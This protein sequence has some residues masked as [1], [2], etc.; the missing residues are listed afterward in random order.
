MS[1]ERS[2]KLRLVLPFFPGRWD[3][4]RMHFV[5]AVFGTDLLETAVHSTVHEVAL[6]RGLILFCHIGLRSFRSFRKGVRPSRRNRRA[7]S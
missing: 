6:L 5:H 3:F 2:I 1:A 4:K 7:V